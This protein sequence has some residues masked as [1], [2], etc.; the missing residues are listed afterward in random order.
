MGC[1]GQKLPNFVYELASMKRSLCLVTM[2]F[3]GTTTVV[4]GAPLE[5]LQASENRAACEHRLYKRAAVPVA[6]LGVSKGDAIC[7]CLSD[8]KGLTE[9]AES[10]VAQIEQ[11]ET[12]QK[13]TQKYQLS[14]QELLRLLRN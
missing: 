10:K 9:T 12:L 8:L 7:I 1:G 5:C 3:F 14:E 13:I 2:C 11:Q 6:L 4:N